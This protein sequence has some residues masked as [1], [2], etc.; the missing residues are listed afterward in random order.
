VFID[1]SLANIV[2]MIMDKCTV[3]QNGFQVADGGERCIVFL[4][5]G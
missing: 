4:F 5:R 2:N 3:M 1:Y